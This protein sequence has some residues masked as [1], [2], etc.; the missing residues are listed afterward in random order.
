MDEKY[1]AWCLADT[2]HSVMFALMRVV[3]VIIILHIT[4]LSLLVI[5][6]STFI[7]TLTWM[8]SKPMSPT[9]A[10]LLGSLVSFTISVTHHHLNIPLEYQAQH[11]QIKLPNF[12][13]SVQETSILPVPQSGNLGNSFAIPSILPASL[14]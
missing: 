11:T 7:S 13:I 2:N 3:N 12:T 10:L 14:S 8:I 1:S 6:S 9:W 4:L 5:L